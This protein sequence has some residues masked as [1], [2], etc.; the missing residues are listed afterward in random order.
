MLK[1]TFH[2]LRSNP[3]LLLTYFL[4]TVLGT[5]LV[6]ALMPMKMNQTDIIVMLKNLG[7]TL[8][9]TML[10]SAI[11]L[12]FISGFGHM[13]A[14]AVTTGTTKIGSFMPGL[15]IAFVRV[16][17]SIL[18]FTAMILGLSIVLGIAT[19]PLMM[20]LIL[21]DPQH[22]STA[23]SMY[24][25]AIT[26]FYMVVIMFCVPFV[27]MWLPAIFI[28][29]M[30]VIKGF[31]EGLKMGVKNYGIILLWGAIA[32]LPVF[33]NMILSFPA[34]STGVFLTPSYVVLLAISMVF[35]IVYLAALF[36]LYNERCRRS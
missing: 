35:M 6:L 27:A 17:L 32:Y 26:S 22:A 25:I 33:A 4:Y 7:I 34:A 21:R 19:M 16:L 10:I 8:L 11:G 14:E 1:K 20:L 2:T 36:T 30:G 29:K 18:L 9:V 31:T 23:G 12:V 24:S 28:D 13:L 3:V 15:R 5:I